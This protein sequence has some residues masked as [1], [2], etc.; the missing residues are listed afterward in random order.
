[1]AKARK[2]KPVKLTFSQSSDTGG[3][4]FH[5]V[6]QGTEQVTE[7][8]P[9]FDVAAK[10]FAEIAVANPAFVPV[11]YDGDVDIESPLVRADD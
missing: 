10:A 8:T 1:M 7:D 5:R 3:I 4:Q 2:K 11:F 6:L 9:F